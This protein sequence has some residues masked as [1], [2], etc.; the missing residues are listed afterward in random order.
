MSQQKSNTGSWRDLPVYLKLLDISSLF[1][2]LLALFGFLWLYLFLNRIV[3][4]AAL[5][6][7]TAV[8]AVLMWALRQQLNKITD[9]EL[10]I[11]VFREWLL[12]IL[13]TILITV[14]FVLFYPIS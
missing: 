5:I 11:K 2:A 14:L 6:F 1:L 3:Q 8:L 7:G 12:L 9:Y 10:K 13:V 4:N